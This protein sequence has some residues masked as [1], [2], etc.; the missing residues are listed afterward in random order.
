[1]SNKF[2]RNKFKQ[3]WLLFE[4]IYFTYKFFLFRQVKRIVLVDIL[5]TFTLHSGLKLDSTWPLPF[6]DT[7]IKSSWKQIFSKMFWWIHEGKEYCESWLVKMYFKINFCDFFSSVNE[8]GQRTKYFICWSQL[9]L[10]FF[11]TYIQTY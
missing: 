5:P 4:G 9:Y 7:Q 1:M 10:M 3:L 2:E 6:L 8:Q 11:R